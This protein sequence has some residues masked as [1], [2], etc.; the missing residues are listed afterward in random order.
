MG[1]GCEGEGVIDAQRM[2][3]QSDDRRVPLT[4]VKADLYVIAGLYVPSTQSLTPVS[5]TP[6]SLAPELAKT[7]QA[8]LVLSLAMVTPGIHQL[9]NDSSRACSLAD[10]TSKAQCSEETHHHL[11]CRGGF[12]E[13]WIKGI[14]REVL[15]LQVLEWP[16]E[17]FNMA[18]LQQHF[19]ALRVLELVNCTTLKTFRGRFTSGNHIEVPPDL[20]SETHELIELDLRSNM[21]R[22]MQTALFT[23]PRLE[24]IYLSEHARDLP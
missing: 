17:C 13:Y 14:R 23:A 16:G 19:P 3:P 12:T 9:R 10:F 11:V 15:S 6:V 7:L 18:H 22:H 5:L 21:L 20:V 4:S 24:R 8:L 2:S 1:Y